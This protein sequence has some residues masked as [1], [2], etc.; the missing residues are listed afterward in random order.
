MQALA[1]F[2][3]LAV[4]LYCKPRKAC[5]SSTG[6]VERENVLTYANTS[7]ISVASSPFSRARKW[8]AGSW[9]SGNLRARFLTYP[10]LRCLLQLAAKL[11]VEQL[12]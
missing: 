1:C 10:T 5:L 11:L 9:L 12:Q 8:R 2:I 4:Q 6:L 3:L 7:S